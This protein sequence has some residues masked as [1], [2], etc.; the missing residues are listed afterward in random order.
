MFSVDKQKHEET[1][2]LQGESFDDSSFQDEVTPSRNTLGN[3]SHSSSSVATAPGTESRGGFRTIEE[4]SDSASNKNGH[5]NV[6][7]RI[8]AKAIEPTPEPANEDVP[9]VTETSVVLS[10]PRT[11]APRKSE[12]TGPAPSVEVTTA[13]PSTV[14]TK[15]RAVDHPSTTDAPTTSRKPRHRRPSSQN[16][17]SPQARP[18]RLGRLQRR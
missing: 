15:E 18:H 9:Q 11:T 3:K 6:A 14:Y 17:R 13:P 5:R 8:Q 1:A 10:T 12:T 4:D 7:T 16:L 2:A